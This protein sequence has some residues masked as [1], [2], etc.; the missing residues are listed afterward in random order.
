MTACFLRELLKKFW[1]LIK[2]GDEVS[3]DILRRIVGCLDDSILLHCSKKALFLVAFFRFCVSQ[4]CCS[5]VRVM[6]PKI[7]LTC[8]SRGKMYPLRTMER[9]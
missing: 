2:T 6:D 4:T 8:L 9:S 1:V 7:S 3:V 5:A